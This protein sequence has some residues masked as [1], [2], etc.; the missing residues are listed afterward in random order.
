[1]PESFSPYDA[2]MLQNRTLVVASKT[3]FNSFDFKKPFED[4]KSNEVTSGMFY[5]LEMSPCRRMI[6][7]GGNDEN[8]YLFEASTLRIICKVYTG[9]VS[10]LRMTSNHIFMKQA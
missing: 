3:G 7:V 1:M 2:M 8:M 5:K 6:A 9:N 4:I 10:D